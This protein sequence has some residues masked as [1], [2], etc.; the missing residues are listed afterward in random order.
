MNNQLLIDISNWLLANGLAVL[1]LITILVVGYLV[2]IFKKPVIDD[3]EEVDRQINNG[4][5]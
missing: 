2:A 4:Q 1:S 5:G 3:R